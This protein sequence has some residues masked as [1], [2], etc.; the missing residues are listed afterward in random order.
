MILL[1]RLYVENYKLFSQKEIDFSNALLSVFDG[2]NGYGKTSIFDAIELLV[3][4]RISRVFDCESIDGKAA[5][6]TVFFAQ[7]SEKDVI[8]KAEFEDEETGRCFALGAKVESAD[9]NG[10]LAN[11]KNIFD[12][13][14]YFYLPSY[15]ISIDSWS[16]YL[17]DSYEIE[18]I[19]N[20]K[21]GYENVEQFTLFHYIRQ[22]DRL[23]YFKQSETS[24]ATTIENL[25]GVAK[26]SERYKKIQ[27]KR[28]SIDNICKQ[29][30]LQKRIVWSKLTGIS[31]IQ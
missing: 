23:S 1:K 16:Y 31:I 28:K 7:N 4:G 24:R 2:P 10:K 21:F 22:E 14:K 20:H 5:Y 12:K 26:E 9:I 8:L 3:T 6:H 27:E 19:R 11:P 29:K 25:L 15:D 30:L 13:V 18:E 17:Q